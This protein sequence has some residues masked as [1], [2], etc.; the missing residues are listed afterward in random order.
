MYVGSDDK[1]GRAREMS[2][3]R[4]AS[5]Q[6]QFYTTTAVQH[7]LMLHGTFLAV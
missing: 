5:M 7:Y 1:V 6:L 4:R 2:T 3:C